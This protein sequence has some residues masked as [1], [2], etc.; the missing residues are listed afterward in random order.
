MANP[1]GN[2]SDGDVTISSN[3]NLTIDKQYNNLTV[4]GGIILNTAGYTVR[5]KQTLTNNGT[6]TDSTTGGAGGGGGSGG[7]GGSVSPAATAGGNGSSGTG[8]GGNGGG[9][10]GGGGGAGG[11]IG[12]DGGTATLTYETRTVGTA[13]A[14][15]G[16]GGSRGSGG[17]GHEVTTGSESGDWRYGKA[18]GIPGGGGGGRGAYQLRDSSGSGTNGSSGSSGSAGTVTW[19]QKSAYDD[20]GLRYRKGDTTYKIACEDLGAHKLRFRKGAIIVGIPLVATDDSDASPI[21]IYDG[22]NVKALPEV[23]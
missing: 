23:A 20:S 4:N 17:G 18:G 11:G 19:T 13:T 10:G 3:T 16:S 14:S 12:G 8:T 21:R 5:V 9:G 1:Y 15:A 2:G 7:T 6:V 22:S